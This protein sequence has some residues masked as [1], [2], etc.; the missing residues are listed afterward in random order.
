MK[1]LFICLICVK[2]LCKE[3]QWKKGMAFL[4]TEYSLNIALWQWKRCI[5][6][7]EL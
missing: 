2:K 6:E 7:M 4:V 1:R 3:N 5:D